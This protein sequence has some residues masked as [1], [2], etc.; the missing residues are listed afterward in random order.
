MIWQTFA[1]LI[2]L[3]SPYLV[4]WM[5]EWIQDPDFEWKDGFIYALGISLVSFIKIYGFRR[6][7]YFVCFNQIRTFILVND[8]IMKKTTKLSASTLG[9]VEVGSITSMTAGDANQIAS[10]SFFIN[11]IISVPIIIIGITILLVIEFGWISLVTPVIFILLT[12]IQYLGTKFNMRN[13]FGARARIY[14]QM[15]TYINEMIKGIKSIKFNGWELISLD[16]IM[17]FR[18][19]GMHLSFLFF[20]IQMFMSYLSH[21]FPSMTTLVIL[22]YVQAYSGMTLA[23]SYF[24]VGIT[25]LLYYPGRMIVTALNTL[26]SVLVGFG[27]IDKFLNLEEKSLDIQDDSLKTG[28]LEIKGVTASWIN[29]RI[30]DAYKYKGDK[31]SIA[32]KNLNCTFEEGKLYAII[33]GVGAGKSS[34]LY[35]ALGEL[36]LKSGTVKK[37][38]SI[39]FVP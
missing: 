38:G 32:V 1:S 3:L 28:N 27:R 7:T 26:S 22:W 17:G 30:A 9:I 13:V 12:Y 14:D 31:N 4:K 21:L 8:V 35:S 11:A 23:E 18:T 15:G 37:N 10:L 16:K 24:L 36:E 29:P 6:A 19:A 20:N 5:I 34:L 39:A 2:E 25:S 33:G